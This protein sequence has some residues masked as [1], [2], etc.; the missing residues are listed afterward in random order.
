[1]PRLAVEGATGQR[2][3]TTWLGL[4]VEVA[5]TP[6]EVD[7]P[8]IPGGA[9][10]MVALLRRK[11]RPAALTYARARNG[12]KVIHTLAVRFPGG[13]CCWEGH[14]VRDM[15]PAGCSLVGEGYRGLMARIRELDDATTG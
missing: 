11:G 5:A 13:W 2:L 8:W 15:S 7:A 10:A 6:V 9:R 4:R 14:D 12:D 1:M 3:P